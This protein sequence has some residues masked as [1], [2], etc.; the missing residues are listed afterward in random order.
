M[1]KFKTILPFALIASTAIIS[2]SCNNKN[3][4]IEKNNDKKPRA[5]LGF[6]PKK[7]EIK[8]QEDFSDLSKKT[9]GLL[10]SSQLDNIKN[11]FSFKLTDYG[12]KLSAYHQLEIIKKLRNKL[13]ANGYS[14]DNLISGLAN[15]EEFK[16]YFEISYPLLPFIYGHP[17]SIKLFE[18]FND[19]KVPCIVYEVR[20]PDI[21]NSK[22]QMT[23]ET[24]EA[25]YLDQI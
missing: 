4:E 2:S 6:Q 18:E 11:L 16:K 19:K 3:Q 21:I 10:D 14:E 1:I 17:V 23:I 20:C 9:Y 24:I 25:I 8:D 12:R 13:L 5:T 22:G 7:T 15:E